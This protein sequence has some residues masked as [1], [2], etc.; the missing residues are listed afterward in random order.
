VVERVA[1]DEDKGEIRGSK[2]W[3]V[4]DPRSAR[5]LGAIRIFALGAM[6]GEG[7]RSRRGTWG[8]VAL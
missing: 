4:I 1:V 8:R 5:L 7:S 3:H 6:W 2:G